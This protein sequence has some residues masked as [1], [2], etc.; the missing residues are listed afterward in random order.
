MQRITIRRL[1]SLLAA[2]VLLLGTAQWVSAHAELVRSEPAAGSSVAAAPGQVTVYYSEEIDA[3]KSTITVIDASGAT[4]S[5]GAATPVDGDPK[6]MKVALQSGLADGA[7][8]V[9]WTNTS[10]DGHS[11]E[12]NFSFT[13]G[14]TAADP[15][16]PVA[17]LPNT[18]AT[19]TSPV[20]ILLVALGLGL[21]GLGL[22]RG[23]GRRHGQG[24]V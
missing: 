3:T 1:V 18:G 23:L 7:Y 6:A 14:A 24:E 20:V 8:T 11:E 2:F 9:Q 4:V 13:V 17:Q 15:A 10:I 16:E 19:I 21:A 22:R 5:Q 12:G